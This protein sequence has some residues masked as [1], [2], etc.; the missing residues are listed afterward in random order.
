MNINE[1]G[2]KLRQGKILVIR[3]TERGLTCRS[4]IQ[5]PCSNSKITASSYVWHYLL[6]NAVTLASSVSILATASCNA[7]VRRGVKRP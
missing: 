4:S 3:T 5:E 6:S 7:A 1:I 2:V